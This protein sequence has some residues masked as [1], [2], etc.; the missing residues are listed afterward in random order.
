MD[1]TVEDLIDLGICAP[2]EKRAITASVANLRAIKALSDQ[3]AYADKHARLRTLM[4]QNPQHWAIDSETGRFYGITHQPTGFRFHM[5]KTVVPD[6]IT[7]P[8]AAPVLDTPAPALAKVAGLF[9]A[10]KHPLA[11]V[12]SPGDEL[13]MAGASAAGLGGKPAETPTLAQTSLQNK[14]LHNQLAEHFGVP[15]NQ[16]YRESHFTN[17]LGAD[18]LDTVETIMEAEEE[19]NIHIPDEAAEKMQT[20]GDLEDY[21][22]DHRNEPGQ[23]RLQKFAMAGRALKRYLLQEKLAEQSHY[24]DAAR[25][26]AANV[27]AGNASLYQ[28]GEGILGSV[29][30]HLSTIRSRGDRAIN[31]A[32]NWDRMQNA[33]DPNRALHQLQGYISGTRSPIVNHPLDRFLQGEQ[34]G[35]I[36]RLPA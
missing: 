15:H 35:L 34:V 7:R 1:C 28:P 30:R 8:M 12:F 25:G 22:E 10:F 20:A 3:K 36:P 17:D 33:A 24:L 9:S 32:S 16:I 13:L 6:A 11:F 4:L 19:H 31:E 23:P 5:P 18:S 21:I 29:N 27:L 2:D 14:A 26:Q